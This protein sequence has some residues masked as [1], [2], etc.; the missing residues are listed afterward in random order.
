MEN[1]QIQNNLI[2]GSLNVNVK[3]FIFLGSSCIYPKF[4]SQPLTPEI[5]AIAYHSF[6]GSS[7]LVNKYSSFKA[8]QAIREQY[9]RDYVSLMP[10]NLYVILII[11]IY[12][13]HM[14]YRR[15]YVSFTRLN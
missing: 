5:F 13:P 11:L 8:C 1:M 2:D 10:T 6:V 15:C 7:E 9:N 4:A 3:K 14:S 12:N